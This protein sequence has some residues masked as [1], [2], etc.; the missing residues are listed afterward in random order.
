[1]EQNITAS[2]QVAAAS[3]TKTSWTAARDATSA[4]TFTEYSTST[5]N[6]TT[7]VEFFSSG[8]GGGTYVVERAFFFFDLSSINGTITA[9]ELYIYGVTNDTIDQVMVAK[10]DAFGGEGG[11]AFVATDFDN[12]F[13]DNPTAYLDSSHTWSINQNNI[14]SLNSTAVSDANTDL[15][16]TMVVLGNDYDFENVDP[17]GDISRDGGVR[18]KNSTDPV[19]LIVY[20]VPKIIGVS[21][22]NIIGVSAANISSVIGV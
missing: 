9:M 8:R 18:F 11:S 12:W 16:L 20:Y 4:N 10:S 17:G 3:G 1:M 5:D 7:L 21:A 15:A 22:A 19:K 14:L 6:A 13:P 2:R